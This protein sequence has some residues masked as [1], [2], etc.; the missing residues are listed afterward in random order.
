ML[1]GGLRPERVASCRAIAVA[2]VW[3]LASCAPQTQSP[4]VEATPEG[5]DSLDLANA[6][7]H[8]VLEAGGPIALVGGRWEG[9]PSA[10]GGTAR[11]SAQLVTSLAPSGDLDGDGAAEAVALL[12]ASA[13]GTGQ[14]TYAAVFANR[15]GRWRNVA[16]ASLGDRVQL[17]DARIEQARLVL[18]VVQAGPHDAMCCPGE[19]ATRTWVLRGDSLAES[20]ANVTG[21]LGP[22]V[23]RGGE[24]VLRSWGLDEAASATPEVT[25]EST[26]GRWTGHS[27]CNR[28]SAAVSPGATP[29]EVKL[30]P[31]IGTRMACPDHAGAVE[32]RY[33]RALAGVKKFSF[34][35]GRLAL[36]YEIDG[37]L[38]VL[39]FERRGA[40]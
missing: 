33:L 3:L 34:Q 21:R 35:G 28:Y 4:S 14:S 39:L 36:T 9:V 27:G 32:A 8:G 20:P 6:T 16:S 2:V 25:L 5:T 15:E 1:T 38:G 37:T 23:L 31:A 11:P 22:E 29:G 30:G 12:G 24:W 40:P 7:Y 17:R 19:L 13:G 10:A 18:D 26:D